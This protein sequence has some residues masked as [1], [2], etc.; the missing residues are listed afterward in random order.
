MLS[1]FFLK[2]K[3]V[4]GRLFFF[5]KRES[6]RLC[7]KSFFKVL[8]LERSIHCRA[9]CGSYAVS[10]V[11]VSSAGVVLANGI[12]STCESASQVCRSAETQPSFLS[13]ML[14]CMTLLSNSNSAKGKLSDIQ[15]GS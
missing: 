5:W 8:W 3:L 6:V 15:D 2:N 11:L 4:R 14:Y 10:K 12:L 1:G 9:F 13:Q 7:I